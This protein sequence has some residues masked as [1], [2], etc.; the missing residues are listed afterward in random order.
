MDTDIGFDWGDRP[1]APEKNLAEPSDDESDSDTYSVESEDDEEGKA[2][3]SSHKSRK[4]AAARR[5]EEKEISKR[6]S[7]LAD[8]TADDNPETSADFER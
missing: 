8:G 5:R 6:E 7:A 2:G 3:S 1:I 4:K